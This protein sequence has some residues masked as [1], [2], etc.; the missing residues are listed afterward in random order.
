MPLLTWNEK[1]SV[2]IKAI[3]EQHK[4]WIEILNELYDAMKSARGSEVVGKVLREL[5]DYTKVHFSAEEKLMESTGYS[6]FQG[7]RK[8][9]EDMAK[10]VESLMA[11]QEAGGTAVT[12]DVMFF[13][14]N[15]LSE[16]I[17][18]TDK[19]YSTYLNSRGVY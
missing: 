8:M 13:L 4:R 3:D 1:Y 5:V 10:E 12:V 9:H 14:R 15:W 11:K 7:H 18:G 17:V 2:N 19:N 16:H 6:L